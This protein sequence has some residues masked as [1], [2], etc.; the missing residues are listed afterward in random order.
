MKNVIIA[1]L[2]A[3]IFYGACEIKDLLTPVIM[4]FLVLVLL[5][6]ADDRLAEFR[7]S[8]RRGKRLNKKIDKMKEV[9]I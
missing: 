3:Y 8:V 1:A 7:L 2:S 5:L 9:G 4:F 6:D